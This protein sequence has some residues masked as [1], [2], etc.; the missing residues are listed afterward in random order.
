MRQG[1]AF[2]LRLHWLRGRGHLSV[3]EDVMEDGEG[4]DQARA[5]SSH[6]GSSF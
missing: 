1:I 6:R 4:G 3:M 5:T 2:W